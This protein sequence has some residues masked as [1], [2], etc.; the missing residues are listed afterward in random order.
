MECEC[1]VH[2]SAG[3][4]RGYQKTPGPPPTFAYDGP[5]T[6]WV[7]QL[8]P[9]SILRPSQFR[10]DGPPRL[11]SKRWAKDFNEVKEFGALNGSLRTPEQTEIGL[12][13]GLIN[14]NVQEAQNL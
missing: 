2:V 8:T 12:F 10:A 5:I 11:R 13:Y 9:F 1:A 7:K 3:R 14:A 4:S 6:P